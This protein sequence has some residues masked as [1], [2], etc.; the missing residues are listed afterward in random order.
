[1]ATVGKNISEN[2]LNKNYI[3]ENFQNLNEGRYINECIYF[4]PITSEQIVKFITNI[5]DHCSY[6][7]KVISNK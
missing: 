5:I 6:Y 4:T 1:M 2:I 7:V 3:K